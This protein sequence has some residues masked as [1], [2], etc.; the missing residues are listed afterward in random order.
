MLVDDP[1]RLKRRR[2]R[3]EPHGFDVVTRQTADAEDVDGPDIR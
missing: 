1:A 2:G 3:L